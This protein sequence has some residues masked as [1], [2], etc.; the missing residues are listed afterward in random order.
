MFL[1]SFLEFES[2]GS[3]EVS[4]RTSALSLTYTKFKKHILRIVYNTLIYQDSYPNHVFLILFFLKKTQ[5][6]QTFGVFAILEPP[7]ET[8]IR[9]PDLHASN[10]STAPPLRRSARGIK[11][12]SSRSGGPLLALAVKDDPPRTWG[13]YMSYPLGELRYST[14]KGTFECRWWFLLP[15]RWDIMRLFRGG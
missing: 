6:L 9:I 14:L 11:R 5:Q 12:T 7:R 10:F 13:S 15:F 4:T 8:S 3:G 1:S 2:F